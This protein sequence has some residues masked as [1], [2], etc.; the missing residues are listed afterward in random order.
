MYFIKSAKK[1]KKLSNQHEIFSGNKNESPRLYED[2]QETRKKYN[3]QHARETIHMRAFSSKHK[4][5]HKS[6]KKSLCSY[7][8]DARH[9]Y[10]HSKM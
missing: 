2:V 1:L 4:A 3:R 9:Q 5:E 7:S 10:A 6:K 8:H